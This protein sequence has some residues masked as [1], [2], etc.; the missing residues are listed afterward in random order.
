MTEYDNILSKKP[1]DMATFLYQFHNKPI[2]DI[3]IYK[4][5]VG[6]MCYEKN[7]IHG[8]RHYLMSEVK[9]DGI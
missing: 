3:C 4:D 5:E 6:V 2:C 8:I 1:M 9:E 7:C